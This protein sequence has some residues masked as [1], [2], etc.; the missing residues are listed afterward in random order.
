[1]ANAAVESTVATGRGGVSQMG[2]ADQPDMPPHVTA[3]GTSFGTL[4][5]GRGVAAMLVVMFHASH[6]C[7]SPQYGHTVVLGG[8]FE[9]G[10]SGV[11]FFFVLSGFIMALVHSRDIGRPQRLGNFIR[12]RLVRIYPAYW[13]MLVLVV[14]IATRIPNRQVL[15]TSPGNL[16]FSALL[17]GPD[18]MKSPVGVAWT[19]FH[20]MLYYAVFCTFI[21]S[22]RLGVAVACLWLATVAFT[23]VNGGSP[24]PD[25]VTSPINLLFGMGVLSYRAVSKGWIKSPMTVL[26]GSFIVFGIAARIEIL[27]G[28]TGQLYLG[29]P[30]GVVTTVGYGLIS[31]VLLAAMVTCEQR[32]AVKVPRLGLILGSA[33]YSI[34]LTHGPM[35][36]VVGRV[37]VRLH[38]VGN[39][40]ILVIFALFVGGVTAV[41]IAFHYAV[42]A[43]LMRWLTPRRRVAAPSLTAA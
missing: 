24:L 14:V 27:V 42:E 5:L 11:S 9:F 1:M 41:G 10:H 25:Y 12:K 18:N 31:M 4:Q 6:F 2:T 28:H 26:I 22:R 33:S 3:K 43:P 37:L 38:L 29:E 7:A 40:P 30:L 16:F 8:F 15:D 32:Y 35:L 21:L 23:Y 34:Y 19:L 17:F 39:L 36:A 13:V 20:E